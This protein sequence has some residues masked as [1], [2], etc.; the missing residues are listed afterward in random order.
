L[1]A[2]TGQPSVIC[3]FC[4]ATTRFHCDQVE[5]RQVVLTH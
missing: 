1:I 2:I 3:P 5:R 4:K